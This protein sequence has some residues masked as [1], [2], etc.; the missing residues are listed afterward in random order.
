MLKCFYV[1]IIKIR[2]LVGAEHQLSILDF[3][4]PPVLA[5]SF[6]KS[7]AR[8]WYGATVIALLEFFEK[9]I[10]PMMDIT[11]MSRQQV[12]PAV[13]SLH[14][15]CQPTKAAA[16][17]SFSIVNKLLAKDRNFLPKNAKL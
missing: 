17:R 16:E 15:R 1:K 2:W 5:N 3:G 6:A 4:G 9:V 14:Q 8:H 11:K 13:R 12:A 7:W 10:G